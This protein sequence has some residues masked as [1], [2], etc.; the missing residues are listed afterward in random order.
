MADEDQNGSDEKLPSG[1]ASPD[2]EVADTV[3]DDLT[4]ICPA[5]GG[6][7]VVH[8]EQ[9]QSDQPTIMVWGDGFSGVDDA[10]PANPAPWIMEFPQDVQP[11]K[12]G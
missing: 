4:A 10:P 9:L 8:V 2:E 12:V 1:E 6:S 7:G 3:D 5:C 11:P